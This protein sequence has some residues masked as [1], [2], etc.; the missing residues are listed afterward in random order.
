[1]DRGSA[2]LENKKTGFGSGCPDSETIALVEAKTID[3]LQAVLHLIRQS[4]RHGAFEGKQVCCVMFLDILVGG[5]GE[6][7]IVRVDAR[8]RLLQDHTLGFITTS[9]ERS[10]PFGCSTYPRRCSP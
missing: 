10:L 5:E 4:L 7:R 3:D 6:L 2:A 9:K 8:N 1:M